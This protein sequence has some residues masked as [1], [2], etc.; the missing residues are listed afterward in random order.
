M[1]LVLQSLQFHLVGFGSLA[2][3]DVLP[4]EVGVHH[5][6]NGGVIVQFP[7]NDRDGIQSRQFRGMMAPVAGDDLIPAVWVRAHDEGISYTHLPDALHRL[8]HGVIVQHFEGMPL[9]GVQFGEGEPL[10]RF[11]HGFCRSHGLRFRLFR[12][13]FRHLCSPRF[14]NVGLWEKEKRRVPS[15][16]MGQDTRLCNRLRTQK[17]SGYR[18][19]D[20]SNSDTRSMK[21][22]FV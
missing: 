19:P 15:P 11:R 7:D 8:R 22:C 18:P 3:Q 5:H 17:K 21:S 20:F 12:L 13:C 1:A 10:Y 2:G 14:L 4:L 16:S 6:D 9:K